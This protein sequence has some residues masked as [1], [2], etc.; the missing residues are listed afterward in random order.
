MEN[1]RFRCAHCRKVVQMR[2]VGQKFCGAQACQ[3]A[4]NKDWR[5]QKYAEDAD[6]RLNQ[7][8]STQTW[9]ETQG[10]SAEY[11]RQYRRRRKT[12]VDT[13]AKEKREGSIEA[14][15]AFLCAPAVSESEL[16]ANRNALLAKSPIKTGRYK[17]WP[18]SANRNALLV[19]I[20]VI[21][22]T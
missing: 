19:E 2:V 22:D 15:D 13:S 1:K 6:Y 16:S 18:A 17:I 8:Q 4:R 10:G 11:Y 9:L 7:K 5:R 20:A 3:R 14:E 21:T 12:Q